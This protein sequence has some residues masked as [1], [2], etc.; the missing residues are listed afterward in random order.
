MRDT[1]I[2]LKFSPDFS[3]DSPEFPKNQHG[4]FPSN[5]RWILV[6]LTTQISL[7]IPLHHVSAISGDY[8]Q[9]PRDFARWEHIILTLDTSIWLLPSAKLFV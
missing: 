6:S 7:W 9:N 8:P 4:K 5:S 3:V 2:S 1:A